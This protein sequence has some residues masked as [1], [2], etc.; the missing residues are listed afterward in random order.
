MRMFLVFIAMLAILTALFTNAGIQIFKWLKLLFKGLNPVFYGVVY[1]ILLVIVFALFVASRKPDIGIPRII[2]LADH[3]A[4]GFVVYMV[5]IVNV[6]ATLI[7]IGKLIH[8]IPAPIPDNLRLIAGSISA[9]LLLV[10][11][12]YGSIHAK[13]I[14]MKHYDIAI[15]KSTTKQE[16]Q[17][18]DSIKI[19]LISDI[20]LGY[21]VDENHLEKVVSKINSMKPDVICIAGDIFDGD[22]TS[23]SNPEKLQTLFKEMKSKYGVYACLGNHDAGDGYNKMIDFLEKSDIIV[24]MDE[25]IVVD[26]QFILAGRRDSSPI[27]MHGEER[28]KL[29]FSNE[30][31][32]PVV[33]MDHQPG[34]INQYSNEADLILCGHTHKGQIFPFGFITNALF[35][36]DYGYYR[37]SD[38]A[39]QVIVTSGIGTWGPP[40]R[41]ASDSEVVEIDIS[42]TK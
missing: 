5:M 38:K 40:Q 39:P 14:Q 16:S 31:N 12:I 7:W 42:L 28:E 8:L 25:A 18:K 11:V 23:L 32:L 41:V 13:N 29:S 3:Y 37:A 21:V 15:N 34:N 6:I 22:I 36:V 17:T 1:G 10:I 20:H 9:I 27:G 19:A 2:L 4:L 33:V 30:E 24:L 35:D 26:N